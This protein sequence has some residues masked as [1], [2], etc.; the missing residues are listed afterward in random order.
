MKNNYKLNYQQRIIDILK[1]FALTQHYL[2]FAKEHGFY[3]PEENLEIMV[4]EAYSRERAY[5]YL[6]TLVNSEEEIKFLGVRSKTDF[7]V[8]GRKV[9]AKVRTTLHTD[10]NGDAFVDTSKWGINDAIIV[11]WED[12]VAAVFNTK[13]TKDTY[14]NIMSTNKCSAKSNTVKVSKRVTHFNFKNAV[15]KW[16]KQEEKTL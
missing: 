8:K 7:L 4:S 3:D 15:I 14:E 11:V 1:S 6:L 5:P 9:D 2:N 16:E 10:F 13:T 12:D